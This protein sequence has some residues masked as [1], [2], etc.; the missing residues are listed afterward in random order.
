MT[1]VEKKF[2]KSALPAQ[3]CFI[4][5]MCSFTGHLNGHSSSSL[6]EWKGTMKR[7]SMRVEVSP[8]PSPPALRPHQGAF[9]YGMSHRGAYTL[10]VRSPSTHRSSHPL[11][12]SPAGLSLNYTK[13]E[14]V[15]SRR[16][17]TSPAGGI[18]KLRAA[19]PRQLPLLDDSVFIPNG[20]FSASSQSGMLGGYQQT[21]Y[22]ALYSDQQSDRYALVR[23][24]R[25]NTQV[26]QSTRRTS[27]PPLTRPLGFPAS[28]PASLVS[29]EPSSGKKQVPRVQAQLQEAAS[30]DVQ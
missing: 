18:L 9:L 14:M 15:Q 6:S 11:Q 4:G 7:P 16:A 29:T 1:S 5:E 19:Q 26:Q 3:E 8:P 21:G 22:D 24:A 10:P 28:Y 12:A 27:H 17:P 30:E 13:S 20:P 25:R 23:Q 2:I